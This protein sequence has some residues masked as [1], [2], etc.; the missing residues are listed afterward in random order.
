[1]T[2]LCGMASKSQGK[3]LNISKIALQSSVTDWWRSSAN[4]PA[5][6]GEWVKPT[7]ACGG[8]GWNGKKQKMGKMLEVTASL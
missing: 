8:V 1:M 5:G 3:V 2:Q 4:Q 7:W 6:P